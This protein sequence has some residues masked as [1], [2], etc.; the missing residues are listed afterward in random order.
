MKRPFLLWAALGFVALQ[1]CREEMPVVMGPVV[2]DSGTCGGDGSNLTWTLMDDGTLTI[3]GEGNMAY[4]GYSFDTN[5]ILPPWYDYRGDI[6]RVVIDEGVT[7]IG[8]N[9]F[10]EHTNLALVS[11]SGSVAYV[12]SQAFLGCTRLTAIQVDDANPYYCSQDSVLFSKDKTVLCTYPGGL[13]GEYAI[14]EG[15]TDIQ[16]YAFYQCAGLTAVAIPDGVT[17]IGE[18]AFEDCT[19]LASIDLPDGVIIGESAFEGCAGL[20]S[21]NIP[22]GVTS[23][24]GRAFYGCTSLSSVTIPDGVTSIE[25]STFYGCASLA[26]I[27][28][29]D[30]VTSIES[31][32]FSN[33][34]ALTSL[35]IPDGVTSI[36]YGTF[37]GCTSL[38]SVTIPDGVTRIEGYAFNGC[39]RLASITIPESVTSIGSDAFD[40][41][42]LFNDDSN[43]TDNVLYIDRCLIAATKANNETIIGEYDIEPGTRLIA[44]GAFWGCYYLRAVVIPEG[45]TNIG[46]R[47]TVDNDR[48]FTI[49]TN[50]HGFDKDIYGE[51]MTLSVMYFLRSAHRMKDLGE[52]RDQVRRDMA[53]ALRL[54]S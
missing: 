11:I 2:V 30:G 37:E 32:A 46:A 21:I 27:T 50:I 17:G 36:E 39:M 33:C 6:K 42:L 18:S 34:T 9:T 41:T 53:E 48:R 44:N 28:I 25:Y 45:V 26:S 24:G 54:L 47:P 43:W 52:V 31:G 13:Q 8:S 38:V 35:D 29:P 5:P 16:K 23:I 4:Y 20:A 12:N 15:V 51:R 7:G 14:P 40:N 3:S 1:A 10:S 19:G 49:E 22:D